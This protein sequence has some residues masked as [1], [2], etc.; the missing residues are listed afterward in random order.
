[1]KTALVMAL[2]ALV[3]LCVPRASDAQQ[4]NFSY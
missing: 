2:T 3:A 1:M 4:M